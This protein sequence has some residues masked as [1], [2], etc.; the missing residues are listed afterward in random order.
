M[1]ASTRAWARPGWGALGLLLA[2]YAVPVSWN[3]TT[4]AIAIGLALTITGLIILASTMI[5][6]LR[7]VRRGTEGHSDR[8]VAMMLV[9]LIMT[10]SMAFYLVN[11]SAPDQVSGLRTRTDALYFTLS[12]M[13]TVGYGDVHATGQVARAMVCALIVFSAVVVGSLVRA[14]TKDGPRL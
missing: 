7:H 13:A 10:F 12:T 2:Y 1:T 6:E 8:V 11:L 4:G 5:L 14:H 9:L 3:S